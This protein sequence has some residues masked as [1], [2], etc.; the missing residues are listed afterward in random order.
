M[1]MNN[2]I[3]AYLKLPYKNISDDLVECLIEDLL[4]NHTK[5]SDS[6]IK[7]IVISFCYN[8]LKKYYN[9]FEVEVHDA[10]YLDSLSKLKGVQGLLLNRTVYLAEDIVL[11]IRN[12][13]MEIFRVI[14]HE[15]QH[16]KQRHLIEFNDISYRAYLLIMEQI[17]IMEMNDEYYKDNYY[18]FFEEID[19]RLEAEFELYDFLDKHNSDLLVEN[20]DDILKSVNDCE[21]EASN[22]YRKVKDKNINRE[23]L[24][25]KIVLRHP[26][27]LEYYPILNFYYNPDGT[28]IPIS[29]IIERKKSNP[30]NSSDEIFYRKVKLLDKQIIDNRS[31]SKINLKRD[32]QSLINY[33]PS[34]DY[35]LYIM[36]KSLKKLLNHVADNYDGNL[37]NDIY[38][39]LVDKVEYFKNKINESKTKANMYSIKLYLMMENVSKR[40][41]EDK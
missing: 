18:Y 38:D 13:N 7:K 20:I 32:I 22:V 33:V 15:V 30:T 26:E 37:L 17:I 3:K 6:D 2:I 29:S 1:N 41:R 34:D 23:E 14:L 28:K 19:A 8:K 21:E 40:K 4:N 25:D 35:E 10:Q 16:I 9:D 36:E 27:Y 5:Y 11:D 31:G 39:T 24:F 12:N